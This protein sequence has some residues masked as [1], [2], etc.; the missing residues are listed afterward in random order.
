LALVDLSDVGAVLKQSLVHLRQSEGLVLDEAAVLFDQS[1]LELL[2]LGETRVVIL[3][4][5]KLESDVGWRLSPKV[6]LG[7]LIGENG[8]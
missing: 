8:L 5:R 3:V 7:G 4:L 6:S 1:H 2:L